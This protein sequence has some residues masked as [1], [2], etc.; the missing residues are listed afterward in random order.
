MV[1]ALAIPKKNWKKPQNNRG[2]E[3]RPRTTLLYED[4]SRSSRIKAENVQLDGLKRETNQ[5]MERLRYLKFVRPST[6]ESYGEK[7]N[8]E[9]CV[10][11]SFSILLNT[12]LCTCRVNFYKAGQRT[13]RV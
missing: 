5:S 3:M 7:L 6:E 10:W 2:K 13:T 11:V 9:I 12:K 8:L 4:C 1:S